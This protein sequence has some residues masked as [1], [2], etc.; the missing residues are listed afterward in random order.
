MTLST[1]LIVGVRHFG[2]AKRASESTFEM[3]ARAGLMIHVDNGV[4]DRWRSAVEGAIHFAF[5]QCRQF[6]LLGNHERFRD[7][8]L[9]GHQILER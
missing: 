5:F 6:I 7:V 8:M 3:A 2:N 4:R 9:Q 1:I